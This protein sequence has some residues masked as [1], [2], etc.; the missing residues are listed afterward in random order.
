[1]FKQLRAAPTWVKV[2]FGVIGALVAVGAIGNL[3]E[4]D[5]DAPEVTIRTATAT[6]ASTTTDVVASPTTEPAVAATEPPAQP[7]A[8]PPTL[9]PPRPTVAVIQPLVPA[10]PTASGNCSPAYPDVCIPPPPPDLTCKQIPQRRFRVLPP[11]PHG[12]D[13]SDGD[14]IGCESD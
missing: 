5:A 4:G 14:G 3:V 1:M 6:V 2:V 8:A 7:T 12:F 10:V 13:G 9:A 11:D